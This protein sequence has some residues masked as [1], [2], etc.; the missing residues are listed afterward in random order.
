LTFFEDEADGN[1]R[2]VEEKIKN[3]RKFEIM[4][5]FSNFYY[6]KL[7]G[8]VYRKFSPSSLSSAKK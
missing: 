1:Q 5:M 2:E 4:Q 7:A 8:K 3:V 6:E